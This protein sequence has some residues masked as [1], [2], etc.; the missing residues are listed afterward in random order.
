M[1]CTCVLHMQP[2]FHSRYVLF[3]IFS[4]S[5]VRM[6][7]WYRYRVPVPSF[8]FQVYTRR[9]LTF[10]APSSLHNLRTNTY[11]WINRE[12]VPSQRPR[13]SVGSSATVLHLVD[14]ANV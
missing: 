2:N 11:Y 10:S 4:T 12:Q 6:L 8:K 14:I 5:D 13:Y 3:L 7:E 1:S 9:W